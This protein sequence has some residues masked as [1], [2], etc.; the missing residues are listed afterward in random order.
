MSQCVLFA[1]FFRMVLTRL[2]A[3]SQQNGPAPSYEASVVTKQGSS[4]SGGCSNT[5]VVPMTE[6]RNIPR[7]IDASI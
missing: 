7:K 5:S 3:T 1:I 4:V 6:V 2:G